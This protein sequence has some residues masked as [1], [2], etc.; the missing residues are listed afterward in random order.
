MEMKHRAKSASRGDDTTSLCLVIVIACL[1][2]ALLFVGL[3]PA[4][5]VTANQINE[6]Q[7]LGP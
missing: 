2:G 6:I 1:T 4:S 3:P 5:S 7:L